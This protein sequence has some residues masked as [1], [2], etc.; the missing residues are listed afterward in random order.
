MRG[1]AW[2]GGYD[3]S[4]FALIAAISTKK[5]KVIKR[6]AEKSTKKQLHMNKDPTVERKLQ[7]FGCR[8]VVQETEQGNIL[9]VCLCMC[10]S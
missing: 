8:K 10:N 2:V 3:F 1:G 4:I 7:R 6:Q 5:W 9:F